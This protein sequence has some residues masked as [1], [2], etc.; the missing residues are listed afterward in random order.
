MGD[1]A[2]LVGAADPDAGRLAALGGRLPH[3]PLFAS[4]EKMLARVACDV[5][6][7]ATEPHAHARLIALGMERGLHVLC[8][9]P[10][11]VTRTEHEA[12]SRTCARRPDLALVPVHQYRYSPPWASIS[13]WARWA[14]RLRRPYALTV[15]LQR[16]GT[17]RHA[18]SPWRA[19]LTTAGGM[20]ADAGVHFLAL[21]W[22]IDEQLD[23][24]AAVRGS[25]DAGHE[26][27]AAIM[28]IGPGILKIQV[29]NGAPARHTSLELRLEGAEIAWRDDVATLRLGGRTL[30]RRR[31]DALSDRDHVD[32]LYA[33]LYR[34]L[35]ANLGRDVWRM[36]RTAEALGVGDALVTLLERTPVDAVV[37]V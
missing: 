8:E 26:R 12:V 30:L 35:V 36:R 29:W 28:R 10:L 5:L 14:A 24:L 13:C 3:V 34:D 7:V 6:V 32:G 31:V 23:L 15:D 9:K 37:G 21:A 2:T 17:D 27:S 16:D 4:T 18:V 20:L 22:T 11:T 25:D 1:A 19:D 33:V